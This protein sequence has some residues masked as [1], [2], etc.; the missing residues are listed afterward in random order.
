LREENTGENTI[1]LALYER[2]KKLTQEA[3][4]SIFKRSAG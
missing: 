4:K 2:E 1:D 3:F